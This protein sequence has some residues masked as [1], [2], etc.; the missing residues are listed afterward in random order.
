MTDLSRNEISWMVNSHLE[1][2]VWAAAYAAWLPVLAEKCEVHEDVHDD[3]VEWANAAVIDFRAS[4]D[5]QAAH[6][7]V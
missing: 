5:A 2:T 7:F 4:V 6:T 3:A 1:A